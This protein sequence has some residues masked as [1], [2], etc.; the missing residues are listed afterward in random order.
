MLSVDQMRKYFRGYI[1]IGEPLASLTTFKVGGPADFYF[2]PADA[3]DLT[4]LVNL[5]GEHKL[6][7]TVISSGSNILVSD[8]GY[9]GSAVNLERGLNHIEFDGEFLKAGAGT[10]L[11]QLIDFC[12]ENSLHGFEML[13]EISGTL[14]DALIENAGAYGGTVS[15]HLVDVEVVR[16]GGLR[17]LP[18][19]AVVFGHR[20]SSL[21]DD[22]VVGATFTLPRGDRD[23]MKRVRRELLIRRNELQTV[24]S[25]NAG[26]IFKNPA[27]NSAGRLIESCGLKGMRMGNAQVSTKHANFIINLG[28][29]RADDVVRLIRKIWKEV[30]RKFDVML[31]LEVKLMGFS[32]TSRTGLKQ[33]EELVGKE[34]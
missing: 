23:E 30:H 24:E 9:R 5:L 18:R 12:I 21:G 8:D 22:I 29:A 19:E 34:A 33:V 13:V 7:F 25:P 27:M 14:G 16:R 31:E 32:G 6:P 11:S 4:V 10:K 3:G 20:Y 1:G 28:S 2:E 15:D 17:K 26:Y